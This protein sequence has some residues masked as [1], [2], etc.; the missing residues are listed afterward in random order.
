MPR[1]IDADELLKKSRRKDFI[2]LTI[3]EQTKYG[4]L[5]VLKEAETDKKQSG[6][7]ILYECLC[8]CGRRTLADRWALES[9]HK[10]KCEYCSNHISVCENKRKRKKQINNTSEYSGVDFNRNRWRAR[11]TINNKTYLLG[12]YTTKQ[13]AVSARSAAE[14]I[15]NIK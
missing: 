12:S 5:T 10:T 14:M 4:S 9:G 3:S 8:D 1:Y 15:L 13:E 6:C 2:P 11:I 7:R